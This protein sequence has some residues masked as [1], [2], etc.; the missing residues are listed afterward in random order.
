M[1]KKFIC[2]RAVVSMMVAVTLLAQEG[3]TKAAEGTLMLDKKTYQLT[4]SGGV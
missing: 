1:A 3:K 2:L 4:P